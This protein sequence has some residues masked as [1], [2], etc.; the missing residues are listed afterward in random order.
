[1]GLSEDS[2]SEVRGLQVGKDWQGS[3]GE[4][5]TGSSLW[6]HPHCS[7]QLSSCRFQMESEL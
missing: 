2:R 1:V 4:I 3:Q 7:W 5:D 6:A